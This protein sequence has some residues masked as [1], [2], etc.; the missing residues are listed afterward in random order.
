MIS[1][2]VLNLSVA[3]GVLAGIA[4]LIT[5]NWEGFG[6]M[7]ATLGIILGLFTLL[8]VASPYVLIASGVALVFSGAALL[9]AGGIGEF[10]DCIPILQLTRATMK[11]VELT[12]IVKCVGSMAK[13]LSKIASLKFPSEFDKNG[14]GT[15]Y[16][17]MGA[18][19]FAE[20]ASNGISIVSFFTAMFDDRPT[21]L[22]VGGKSVTIRPINMS[23]LNKITL[24]T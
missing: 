4:S 24:S 14:R 3:V 21:T 13:T 6:Y 8:A 2:G 9:L 1:V 20:A 10:I 5:A 15:K 11:A 17:K 18:N 22:T 23:T 7:A 12:G 16:H 19:D